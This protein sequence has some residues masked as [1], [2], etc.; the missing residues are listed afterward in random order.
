MLD[1][2]LVVASRLLAR[3][4]QRRF[5]GM[6]VST[7]TTATPS[8]TRAVDDE[9]GRESYKNT[10]PCSLWHCCFAYMC[11]L[12]RV[13][14][15]KP[16]TVADTMTLRDDMK[17]EV[18]SDA[19][20]KL[21][22]AQCADAAE[23]NSKATAD[24]VSESERLL[25]AFRNAQ[26]A[27]S[28]SEDAVKAAEKAVQL[29]DKTVLHYK[30]QD[31][32]GKQALVDAACKAKE[33][34]R[35]AQKASKSAT[36]LTNEARVQY[37]ASRAH[38]SA[39]SPLLSL[40]WQEL[41]YGS[42]FTLL[43]GFA[44]FAGPY[45]IDFISEKMMLQER[46]SF[47][48]GVSTVLLVL[49]GALF[50]ALGQT[51]SARV[52]AIVGMKI[53]SVF[54]ASVFKKTLK[55]SPA[56]LQ[57]ISK[58]RITNLMSIDSN[59]ICMTFPEL[60]NI[61]SGVIILVLGTIMIVQ[62]LGSATWAGFAGMI[63]TTPITMM[64]MMSFDK[65]NTARLEVADR[66]IEML[67]E[68]LNGIRMIKCFAWEQD[69]E[70]RAETFRNKE[71]ASV[72]A[73]GVSNI[74]L[75]I[76]FATLPT[77]AALCS[78][79]VYTGIQ[80]H[81]LT[82]GKAFVTL[83]VYN[84]IQI[85]LMFVPMMLT[86]AV[87]IL[88]S[89]RRLSEFL[90]EE[91]LPDCLLDNIGSTGVDEGT[92]RSAESE[93][94]RAD[95]ATLAWDSTKPILSKLSFAIQK[96]KITAIVGAV[97][98]GKSSILSA[99]LGEMVISEG[100]ISPLEESVC[101]APQQAWIVNDTVKGNI[102]F[103]LPFDSDWY[104]KVIQFCCL[105]PDLHLMPGGDSTEIGERG[106]NLSG[107]QKARISLARAVYSRRKICLLDDPLAAVD[108]NVGKALFDG[109]L[110]SGTGLMADTT[111]V[112]VTNQLQVLSQV[113]DIIV[114][115]SDANGQGQLAGQGSYDELISRGG[116]IAKLLREHNTAD[117][118]GKVEHNTDKQANEVEQSAD[119]D[120]DSEKSEKLI[121][122]E[123]HEVGG[124]SVAAYKHYM[125]LGA[126]AVMTVFLGLLV[127]F[128]EMVR[129]CSDLWLAWWSQASD[130]NTVSDGDDG[131]TFSGQYKT[132][133]AAFFLLVFALLFVASGLL[134]FFK[135]YAWVDVAVNASRAM[136]LNLLRRVL[137]AP[138]SFFDKT[139]VGR[140]LNRFSADT[141]EIDSEVMWLIDASV[142]FCLQLLSKLVMVIVLLADVVNLVIPAAPVVIYA[143]YYLFTYYAK[144]NIGLKQHEAALRS[145]IFAHFGEAID[146]AASIRAYGHNQVARF[147]RAS[148][149]KIDRHHSVYFT[150]KLAECW[151]S[152]FSTLMSGC[153]MSIVTGLVIAN[154]DSIDPGVAALTMSYTI[155][156][157]N[158]MQFV[159]W[160]V[161]ML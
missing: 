12:V 41:L 135:G 25:V 106:I 67:S 34:L 124:A 149:A 96:G 121:D 153:L 32:S 9:P 60:G 51:Q 129:V 117:N 97:G 45:A 29:A 99:M 24:E 152:F 91:E 146:G 160:M 5:A 137:G 102:T 36:T 53:R 89:L 55:L 92:P 17:C 122:E 133:P 112:L 46:I 69:Q 30:D 73:L 144:T 147:E 16:I 145:P 10:G 4:P 94:F 110:K 14:S 37:R 93:I 54:C 100:K 95:N 80:G 114:L 15:R 98:S 61:I 38:P 109:L 7:G 2:V 3:H 77:F 130:D 40:Y 127:V 65:H 140:I 118:N 21:W 87:T 155:L 13:G 125:E 157:A 150:E 39:L 139:P 74:V 134:N 59:E 126:G 103:G 22:A 156:L 136:H 120:G 104:R 28:Q 18:P 83:S 158:L 35:E 78:F 123:N 90:G 101:F 62:Q 85:P 1:I 105:E 58:G 119:V 68:T 49:A 116:K 79:A 143:Y 42:L 20:E 81:Q 19:F 138:V 161:T 27:E 70:S 66:R 50:D 33:E 113:D 75:G 88:N 43:A 48:D 56:A 86:G 115:E 26:I 8:T 148:Q 52:F 107:G 132:K 6:A 111:R 84:I 57:R 63:A 82:P 71:L 64:I 141:N 151:F 154:Q 142:S 76:I 108:V 11:G 44:P 128:D 159:I 23:A 31:P 131:D 47:E 72:R